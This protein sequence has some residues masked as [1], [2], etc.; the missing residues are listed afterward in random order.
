MID[1]LV[2]KRDFCMA[3][4]TAQPAASNT[5]CQTTTP[6]RLYFQPPD[7]TMLHFLPS[8][9]PYFFNTETFR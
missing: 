5:S 7:N 2:Q 1:N 4:P 9:I 3:V 6:F 8:Y